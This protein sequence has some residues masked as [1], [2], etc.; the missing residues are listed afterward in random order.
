MVAYILITIYGIAFLLA[1]GLGE[2]QLRSTKLA[3]LQL[4]NRPCRLTYQE[5]KPLI[6]FNVI[7]VCALAALFFTVFD[8]MLTL[9]LDIPWWMI[10][11]QVLCIMLVDDAWFYIIHRTIHENKYLFKKIHS[12][13][14]RVRT[15]LPL[16]HLYVHPLEW[17][18]SILGIGFACI[19][20]YLVLGYV[21]AYAVFI[22]STMRV[23]HEIDIHSGIRSYFSELKWLKWIGSAEH[24]ELHHTKFHG[25]YSSTFK[26]WDKLLKTELKQ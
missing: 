15:P 13:H 21:S 7:T 9:S 18:I 2:M 26:F 4:S 12:I 8:F 22:Y 23:F 3:S 11:V 16:D 1:W 19:G 5:R 14:H 24:H 25:N 6:A 10:A 17:I 20:I